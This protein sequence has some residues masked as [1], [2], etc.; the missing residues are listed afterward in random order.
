MI[1]SLKTRGLSL[2]LALVLSFS[3]CP[4]AL[5]DLDPSDYS[6]LKE[7]YWA[8]DSIMYCSEWEIVKGYDDGKFYPENPVSGVEFITMVTRTFYADEVAAAQSEKPSD[9]PWYWAN[10]K[11][12]GD[13]HV[14]DNTTTVNNTPMSRYDMAAVLNNVIDGKN[15]ILLVSA[16]SYR[17]YSNGEI[18]EP[19]EG[20]WVSKMAKAA[21]QSIQD[22]DSVPE[23]YRKAV[24]MCYALGALSGMSDGT[25]SGTQ[26]M[27]R[28]Q[29]CVVITRMKNLTEGK[30]P[31][32]SSTPTQPQQPAQP[33][34]P[35]QPE[36]PQQTGSGLLANGQ[37]ATVEN[38]QAI[39][40]E[41]EKEYPT[42]T[43]WGY[44][45]TPNTNYYKDGDK[46]SDARSLIGTWADTTY[47]CGGWA[48]MVS[49]RIFGMTGA[50]ARE[51]KSLD[52][53]RPGDI[54]V[55]FDGAGR[56]GHVA[57]FIEKVNN[58]PYIL[59]GEIH[60]RRT[61]FDENGV[62]HH[63]C[64]YHT[65]DGNV[66]SPSYPDTRVVDWSGEKAALGVGPGTRV[67]IFTR[68]PE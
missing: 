42:G 61:A 16:E 38:V 5:A 11:A 40:A 32:W 30:L 27:T 28:A 57:I 48:A 12:A 19:L 68:Y 21:Q 3:L 54:V 13:A 18:E 64:F 62:G 39:L 26:S 47:G 6:D 49:N 50:P 2:I 66:G 36:P 34:T 56:A 8:Y 29:A 1:K 59:N 43:I 67:L 63:D 41:I 55:T 58:D 35:A 7:G 9:A 23:Q 45:Y 37:P 24:S 17:K 52:E 33:E 65:C 44:D 20:A 46:L 15:V 10:V 25:F 4:A 14:T 22:W 51:V 53:A 60:Y 31:A